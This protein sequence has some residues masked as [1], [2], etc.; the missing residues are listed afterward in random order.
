MSENSAHHLS[1]I[2]F[3]SVLLMGH[4]ISKVTKGMRDGMAPTKMNW[5]FLCLKATEE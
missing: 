2:E 4:E 3:I 1:R 5:P